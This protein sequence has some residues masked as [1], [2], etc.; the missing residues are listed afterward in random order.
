MYLIACA[1]LAVFGIVTIWYQR[2]LRG[3]RIAYQI[4]NSKRFHVSC[5]FFRLGSETMSNMP[6]SDV[7]TSGTQPMR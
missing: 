4:L 7:P 6:T 1:W 2:S 5:L 3:V